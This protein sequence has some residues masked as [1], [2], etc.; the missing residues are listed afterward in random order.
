ML[1]SD[2]IRPSNSPFSS[3]FCSSRIRMVIGDSVLTSDNSIIQQSSINFPFHS[4]RIYWMNC[5]KPQ[6]FSKLDL[7]VGYHQIL[8]HSEDVHK[9]AF[10]T[11]VGHYEFL[12]MSFGLTNAPA[13][14]QSL[15]NNLF[16]SFFRRF[17]LVF[18]D[19]ILVY[20]PSMETHVEH[21]RVRLQILQ[22]NNLFAKR[23]TCEFGKPSIKYLGHVITAR[24]VSTNP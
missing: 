9:T 13:T 1:A 21:L 20:S 11:D 5:M 17:V 10:Q 16:Q 15:M 8:M 4:L 23:S 7:R 22:G 2:I 19:D 14:F 6:V 18:F 24:G 3:P 12:V